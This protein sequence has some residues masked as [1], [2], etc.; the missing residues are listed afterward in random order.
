VY[1][2]QYVFQCDRVRDIEFVYSITR[3]IVDLQRTALDTFADECAHKPPIEPDLGG[4][5][6]AYRGPKKNTFR[7]SE[8]SSGFRTHLQE[9]NFGTFLCRS[10]GGTKNSLLPAQRGKFASH[11][12]CGVCACGYRVCG[13]RSGCCSEILQKI[14]TTRCFGTNLQKNIR[15]KPALSLD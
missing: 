5:A 3:I 14:I 7:S 4:T 10:G 9:L 8:S 12:V 1:A 15:P 13:C 6:N 2:R 11:G